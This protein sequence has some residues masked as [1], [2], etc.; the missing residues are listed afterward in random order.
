MSRSPG[1]A[2]ARGSR[3]PSGWRSMTRRFFNVS[4]ADHSRSARRRSSRAFNS[5]TSVSMVGVSGV[6]ST[7][8]AGTSSNGC[9]GGAGTCTASTLAASRMSCSA[10]RCPRRRRSGRGTPRWRSHPSPRHRRDDHVRQAEALE[11]GDV[12]VAVARC[13][14]A[15]ARRRRCRSCR[16]P[17]SRTRGRGATPLAAGPRR[18]TSSGSGRSPAGG[19]GTTS[20][21]P[22]PA[23]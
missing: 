15:P 6:S 17:S 11:R 1:T 2:I 7:C 20:R 10:R 16:S 8:A 3:V 4:A 14:S 9:A 5:S 12:G 21:G 18:G 23:G 22:S 19:P 13:T